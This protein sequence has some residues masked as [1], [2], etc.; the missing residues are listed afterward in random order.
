MKE[1]MLPCNILWYIYPSFLLDSEL[2]D[3][4]LFLFSLTMFPQSEIFSR[5]FHKPMYLILNEIPIVTY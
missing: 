2:L 4:Y 5:A 1:R 3:L